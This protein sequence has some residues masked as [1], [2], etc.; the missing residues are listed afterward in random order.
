MF[1][2]YRSRKGELVSSEE[3]QRMKSIF[4]RKRVHTAAD[5]A[6]NADERNE[7]IRRIQVYIWDISLIFIRYV[8]VYVTLYNLI[9][10]VFVEHRDCRELGWVNLSLNVFF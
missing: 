6:N 1:K 2:K 9:V 7:K 4:G 5:E 10:S 3:V 8:N